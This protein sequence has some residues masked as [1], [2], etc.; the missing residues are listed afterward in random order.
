MVLINFSFIFMVITLF[1]NDMATAESPGYCS[2]ITSQIFKLSIFDLEDV[3]MKSAFYLNVTKIENETVGEFLDYLENVEHL[4]LSSHAVS[5]KS[6]NAFKDASPYTTIPLMTPLCQA[7]DVS[8]DLLYAD[9]Q[10]TLFVGTVLTPRQALMRRFLKGLVL[11]DNTGLFGMGIL[12]PVIFDK[13]YQPVEEFPTPSIVIDKQIIE[14]VRTTGSTTSSKNEVSAEISAVIVSV[15]AKYSKQKSSTS[16]SSSKTRNAVVS[17]LNKKRELFIDEN[18]IDLNPAFIKT[19]Y[20]IVD[21]VNLPQL[22][23]TE[24]VIDLLNRYG[25]YIPNQFTLGGRL[26]VVKSV[27]ESSASNENKELEGLESKLSAAYGAYSAGIGASSQQG[28]SS[29]NT[30]S[31]FTSNER[32][33]STVDQ[34]MD[35]SSFM[36]N[37]QI[38][39]NWRIIALQNIIPTCKFLLNKHSGLF[40]E[41]RRLIISDAHRKRIR[42]LQPNIDMLHYVNDIWGAYDQPF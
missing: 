38:K 19:L 23:R 29:E 14:T 6:I 37:V 13:T 30:N 27:S 17:L 5:V 32:I 28:S 31:I 39:E 20:D 33:T 42:N 34:A 35:I 7:I 21:N 3:Q 16:K 12:S 36:K 8:Y 24:L 25:W 2:V 9:R 40:A 18:R 1:F 26:D 15:S 22:T 10:Y 41:I 4:A 11:D